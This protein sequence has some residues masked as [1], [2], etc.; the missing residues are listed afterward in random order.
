MRRHFQ[1]VV[2]D[3]Y[4]RTRDRARWKR[5]GIPCG[6][7]T[8]NFNEGV[9]LNLRPFTVA[10]I[11]RKKPNIHWTRDR[12]K[13]P[14]RPKEEYP[15]PWDGDTFKGDRANDR[16]YRKDE[17][18]AAG[19]KMKTS[20]RPGVEPTRSDFMALRW[21]DLIEERKDVMMGK[22]VFKGTRL[23]VEHV[24]ASPAQG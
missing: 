7:E 8:P 13:E 2:S 16:H 23:T 17:K 4:E 5:G 14:Q 3:S 20:Q 15:W 6:I 11:L 19:E 12:C 18:R 24:S 10:G 1:C 21:Q 9:R 22:P